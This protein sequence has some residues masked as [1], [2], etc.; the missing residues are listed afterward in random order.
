MEMEKVPAAGYVIKG[1]PIAGLRRDLS[2]KSISANLL[3]PFRLLE[4]IAAARRILDDFKPTVAVGVG[5][6]ASGP[7]CGRP[8]GRVFPISYRNKTALQEKPINY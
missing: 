4:S 6:Y 7:F 3:L 5:G 2:L 1:L 8:A